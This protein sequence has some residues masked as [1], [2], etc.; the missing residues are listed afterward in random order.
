MSCKQDTS[1]PDDVS[2]SKTRVSLECEPGFYGD[3]CSRECSDLCE[4]NTCNGRTGECMS[5]RGHRT[6]PFCKECA[7]GWYGIYCLLSC[8]PK[9]FNSTCHKVSGTCFSCLG[10]RRG[11]FCEGC[12]D[13]Y[14]GKLCEHACPANCLNQKCDS[15]TA[16]CVS[17]VEGYRGDLCAHETSGMERA[18]LF[19]LVVPFLLLLAL[20]LFLKP[21]ASS[22]AQPVGE[23]HSPT[24]V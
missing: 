14:S 15:E 17:C 2:V 19:L 13:G 16:V 9:C 5:C 1:S 6:G 8:S 23:T 3:N 7:Q 11:Y 21:L 4:N 22:P 20:W 24:S 12:P 18:T 10:K